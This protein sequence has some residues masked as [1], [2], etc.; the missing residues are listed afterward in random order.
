MDTSSQGRQPSGQP[1]VYT[2][3][4]KVYSEVPGELANMVEDPTSLEEFL[5]RVVEDVGRTMTEQQLMSLAQD[6]EKRLRQTESECAKLR[7]IL[8]A[9][10]DLRATSER[11]CTS[12][13]VN[14]YSAQKAILHVAELYAKS[15]ELA[16]WEAARSSELEK[17]ERLDANCNEM[18]SQLSVVEEQL[19]AAEARLLETEAKNQLLAGQTDAALCVKLLIGRAFGGTP[20]G[21]DAFGEGR[22]AFGSSAFGAN[23][24][25]LGQRLRRNE[26]H[27]VRVPS[28]GQDRTTETTGRIDFGQRLRRKHLRRC[29][30]VDAP[31]STGTFKGTPS[32]LRESDFGGR[33]TPSAMRREKNRES[34][35]GEVLRGHAFGAARTRLSRRTTAEIKFNSRA[36]ESAQRRSVKPSVRRR[37]LRLQ[38]GAAIKWIDPHARVSN[39]EIL[40]AEVRR[41][42][43]GIS[44]LIS[45]ERRLHSRKSAERNQRVAT[46]GEL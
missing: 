15:K 11:D 44:I 28:A 4:G 2:P 3:L 13:R 41:L 12:L 27:A 21:T 14:I 8:A 46:S 24:S 42:I 7:K 45:L 36:C 31:S 10:K 16:D 25:I 1:S 32:A 17:R 39:G 33:R 29:A 40:F 19:I 34:A 30:F 37:P 26:T 6:K 9:E 23:A 35:I 18:R 38:A 5:G 22:Y 20:S 43:L